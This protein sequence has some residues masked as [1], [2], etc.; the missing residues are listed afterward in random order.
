M[1]LDANGNIDFDYESDAHDDDNDDKEGKGKANG[2]HKGE[3]KSLAP[4]GPNCSTSSKTELS[5]SESSSC[6]NEDVNNKLAT[7]PIADWRLVQKILCG[8]SSVNG[9]NDKLTKRI[10]YEDENFESRESPEYM[11]RPNGKGRVIIMES[12]R[13]E[14]K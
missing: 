2:K 11:Y 7:T 14:R 13:V 10:A 5:E 6:S 9:T 1:T 12:Y 3:G 4:L 8:A